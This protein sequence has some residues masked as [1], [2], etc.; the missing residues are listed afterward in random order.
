MCVWRCWG[1]GNYLQ[2]GGFEGSAKGSLS[3]IVQDKVLHELQPILD[4]LNRP[5]SLAFVRQRRLPD[6]RL[7]MPERL[8]I[9]K[10]W[11]ELTL[12]R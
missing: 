2:V 1:L 12:E 4:W 11:G 5:R 8:A 7:K 6:V 9:D 3:R 10:V